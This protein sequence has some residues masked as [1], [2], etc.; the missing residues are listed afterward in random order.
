MG[1]KSRTD[2]RTSGSLHLYKAGDVWIPF[3][4]RK[5]VLQTNYLDET[6][7]NQVLLH[8]FFA[9]T[10]HS[11]L[12]LLQRIRMPDKGGLA[13]D[14]ERFC[15]ILLFVWYPENLYKQTL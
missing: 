2:S 15:H 13:A 5:D 10:M 12:R 9:Q 14:N 3:F 8:D 1:F 7:V 11:Q 4:C 6:K